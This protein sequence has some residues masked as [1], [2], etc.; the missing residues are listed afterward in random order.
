MIKW[1]YQKT[2]PVGYGAVYNLY[3]TWWLVHAEGWGEAQ[4]CSLSSRSYRSVPLC[5]IWL[6]SACMVHERSERTLNLSEQFMR[7][8]SEIGG[9]KKMSFDYSLFR[10]SLIRS[11]L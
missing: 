6:S 10:L 1:R 5:R 7:E 4:L 3:H 2:A 11:E 9:Y 8:L